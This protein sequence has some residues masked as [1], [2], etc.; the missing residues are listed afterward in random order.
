MA[1]KPQLI[2]GQIDLRRHRVQIPDVDEQNR[3]HKRQTPEQAGQKY[4]LLTQPAFPNS[5]A[6]VAVH[7]NSDAHF[8]TSLCQLA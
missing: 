5:L 7:R 1:D 6:L 2:A 4:H 3:L 8:L